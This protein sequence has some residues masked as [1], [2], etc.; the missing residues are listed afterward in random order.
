MYLIRKQ[1]K[2]RLLLSGVMALGSL[3]TAAAQAGEWQHS[4]TPYI[5]GTG[6]SGTSAIA[7]P[8]G[9]VSADVDMSF[10]DILSNLD[11]GGMVMYKGQY[12]KWVVMSDLIYMDLGASRTRNVAAVST[13]SDISVEQ[14][15]FELSGGYHITDAIAL[16][17]GMRYNDL[18]S[19][20]RVTANTNANSITRSASANASWVDPIVGIVGEFPLVFADRWSVNLK[21]DVGGFGVGSDFAWQVMVAL[22]WRMSDSWDFSAGYRYMQMDY[23]DVGGSGIVVYD[24]TTQGPGIGATWRF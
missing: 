15:G 9:P 17:A 10:G 14:L 18:D 12:D 22:R 20:V 16:Y 3:G 7:T 1:A 24:M 11:F 23:E 5:W 4:L 6:M 13:R 19:S 8:L 21:G 2:T